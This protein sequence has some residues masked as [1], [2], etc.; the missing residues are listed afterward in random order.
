ML[1]R[2]FVDNVWIAI[3][4]W[5]VVYSSDFVLTMVCARL[6]RAGANRHV[7]FESYELTPYYQKDVARV[8]W[9]SPRFL[10]MLALT[11][12]AIGLL[13]YIAHALAASGEVGAWP[14][15]LYRVALGALLL[16]EAAIHIR[17]FRNLYLFA[18]LR[19]PGAAEGRVAY[20]MRL[21]YR[22]SSVEMA[23][24]AALFLFAFGLTQNWFFLGGTLKCLALA[25]SHWRL[26]FRS[27]PT[28]PPV[29]TTPR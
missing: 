1:D 24:F 28:P 5:A 12:S 18:A 4:V 2:L 8:R 16:S 25:L 21:S 11:C 13:G 14:V 22:T 7:V 6:Y 19:R 17:H 9:I 27:R 29:P 23:G 15:D 3:A 20:P 10:L 26:S